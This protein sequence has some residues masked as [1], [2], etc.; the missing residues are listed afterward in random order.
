[1]G[2]EMGKTWAEKRARIGFD[3]VHSM[4]DD[5]SRLAYSGILPD[6]KG[7]TCAGFIERAGMWFVD[8]GITRIERVMTDNHISYRRTRADVPEALPALPTPDQRQGV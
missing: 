7:A 5:H 6:E 8:Q 3:Y 4:V 1:M 2:R